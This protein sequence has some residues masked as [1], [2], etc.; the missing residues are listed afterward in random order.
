[1][2]ARRQENLE[3]VLVIEAGSSG[4][5]EGPMSKRS[6]R[7][8]TQWVTPRDQRL[9]HERMEEMDLVRETSSCV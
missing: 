5:P 1:M 4:E 6:H 9:L 2:A 8:G 3:S 7:E